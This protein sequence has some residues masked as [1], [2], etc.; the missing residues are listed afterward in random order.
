MVSPPVGWTDAL[1]TVS[2]F[3]TRFKPLR[4]AKVVMWEVGGL[5]VPIS[6]PDTTWM[7]DGTEAERWRAYSRA[8]SAVVTLWY[9][10]KLY[11]PQIQWISVMKVLKLAQDFSG[12]CC[13]NRKNSLKNVRHAINDYLTLS[14]NDIGLHLA[15]RHFPH[16]WHAAYI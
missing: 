11:N 6:V 16:A 7:L 12:F 10:A 9:V 13:K 5:L 1:R 14:G 8:C 15:C 2:D 4:T 3:S